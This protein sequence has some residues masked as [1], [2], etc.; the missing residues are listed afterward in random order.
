MAY[1][2]DQQDYYFG[3]AL[4]VF[5]AKNEDAKPAL[6]EGTA[7]KDTR[8]YEMISDTSENFNL[9]MKHSEKCV[10][11][12]DGTLKWK[13]TITEKEK[14][15]IQELMDS[16]KKTFLLLLCSQGGFKK[17]TTAILTQ[18]EYLSLA[19]KTGITIRWEM[20]EVDRKQSFTIPNRGGKPLNIKTDRI[21]KKFTDIQDAL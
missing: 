18:N 10:K 17:T 8:C 15:R 21:K 9:Y 6:V 2:I 20:A 19:H 11:E 4:A 5:F 1:Y 7:F 16:G 3:A 14:A 12:T 13:F